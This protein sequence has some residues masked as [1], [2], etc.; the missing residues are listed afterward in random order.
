[1]NPPLPLPV[2]RTLKKLGSDIERARLRRNMSQAMLAERIGASVKTVHRMEQGYE[3]LALQYLAR[4]LHVFGELDRLNNLLDTAQ[5]SI[6]LMLMDEKL[7][8]R[9]RP[10]RTSKDAGGQ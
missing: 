10:P 1:M 4:A 7:P 6:G 8:Q 3:G 2:L 5:D 9:A